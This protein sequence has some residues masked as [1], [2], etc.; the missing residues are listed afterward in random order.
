MGDAAPLLGHAQEPDPL[1]DST[2]IRIVFP[3]EVGQ[4]Y[5]FKSAFTFH[6]PN[7][8]TLPPETVATVTIADTVIGGQTWLHIPYWTPF[9]TEYYRLDDSLRV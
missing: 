5:D 9:G 8:D 7:G 6:R 4:A 3:F 2:R 1:P